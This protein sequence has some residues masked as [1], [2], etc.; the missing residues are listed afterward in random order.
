MKL[1]HYI[2][3]M[4]WSPNDRVVVAVGKHKGKHGYIYLRAEKGKYIVHLDDGT[5]E[6]FLKGALDPEKKSK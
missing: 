6:K 2:S 5:K 3:R 1:P 4:S